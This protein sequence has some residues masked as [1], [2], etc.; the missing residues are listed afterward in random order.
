[1]IDGLSAENLIEPKSGEDVKEDMQYLY[2]NYP[3]EDKFQL[4]F[5]WRRW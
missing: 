1:M 2:P 3:G 5:H 4:I